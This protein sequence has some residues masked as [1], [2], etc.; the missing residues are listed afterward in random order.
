MLTCAHCGHTR[1][2]SENYSSAHCPACGIAYAQRADLHA[3]QVDDRPQRP[4]I[5]RGLLVAGGLFSAACAAVILG[6]GPRESSE[7]KPAPAPVSPI[8]AAAK[9]PR[10]AEDVVAAAEEP[11]YEEPPRLDHELWLS[12]TFGER[13]GKEFGL[14]SDTPPNQLDPRLDALWELGRD[15]DEMILSVPCIAAAKPI[16]A[17]AIG[18][19]RQAVT[20]K[21]IGNPEHPSMV[22]ASTEEY[23]RFVNAVTACKGS[24]AAGRAAVPDPLSVEPARP[25]APVGPAGLEKFDEQVRLALA[26]S[27]RWDVEMTRTVELAESG[28]ASAN[29]MF[30]QGEAFAKLQAEWQRVEMNDP[31]LVEVRP[32]YDSS[33]RIALAAVSNFF[34]G[35]PRFDAELAESADHQARF[36]KSIRACRA[37]RQG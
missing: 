36:L 3:Y 2:P 5:P 28:S 32:L 6:F 9:T 34:R 14:I 10:P 33:L 18:Q 35:K 22:V 15:W 30:A 21:R 7:Y 27:Q 17:S 1:L 37:S 24:A 20:A 4:R 29:E 13:L 16:L 31:C 25:M 12:L 11:T 26:F 23:V 8:P 19:A